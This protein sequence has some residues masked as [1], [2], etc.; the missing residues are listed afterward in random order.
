LLPGVTCTC[1]ISARLVVC[2]TLPCTWCFTPSG[3]IIKPASWPTTTR[4][5]CTSPVARLTSTS[6]TQAAQAAPKPGHLLWT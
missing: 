6:A 2:S 5:T 4:L 1:S 3:L